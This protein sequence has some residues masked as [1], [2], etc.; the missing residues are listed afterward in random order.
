MLITLRAY[1]FFFYLQIIC[2]HS[3]KIDDKIL[4]EILEDKESI[5]RRLEETRI[6]HKQLSYEIIEHFH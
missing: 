4:S 1:Y 6:F 5:N 2:V 3:M